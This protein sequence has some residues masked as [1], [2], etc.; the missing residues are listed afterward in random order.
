MICELGTE[1]RTNFLQYCNKRRNYTINNFSSCTICRMFCYL[2]VTCGGCA[3]DC[4]LLE[5]GNASFE[6]RTSRFP[7]FQ[8]VRVVLSRLGGWWWPSGNLHSWALPRLQQ[9]AEI[10]LTLWAIGAS[11]TAISPLPL[12]SKI[13][14]GFLTIVLLGGARGRTLE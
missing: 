13:I 7:S 6:E 11:P 9:L 5:V 8:V 2:D 14:A 10:C 4:T 3:L 12:S 1:G